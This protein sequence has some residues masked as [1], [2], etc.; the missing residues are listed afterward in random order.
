MIEH[1]IS[2]L[3]QKRQREAEEKAYRAYVTDALMIIAENTTHYVGKS[4]MF[5]YGKSLK[6]RWVELMDS[7]KSKKESPDEDETQD[8]EDD[9][10]SAEEFAADIWNRMKRKHKKK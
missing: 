4:D 5:D 1:C 2:T 10:R 3:K 7:A 6:S 8:I 9:T